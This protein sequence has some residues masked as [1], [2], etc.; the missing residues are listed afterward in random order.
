MSFID[1]VLYAFYIGAVA[2]LVFTPGP[3]VSLI[4]AETLSHS[5]KHGM[6]VIAGA[7]LSTSILLAIYAIGF[8]AVISEISDETLYVIRLL[9]AAYLLYLAL[10]AFRSKPAD[11]S[12]V[13]MKVEH[14]AIKAFKAAL[15]VGAT[16]PKAVLF[17]AA[18]FPQFISPD[19]PAQPQLITLTVTFA[20]LA[21]LLDS[22]WVIAAAS[23]RKFLM[24]SGSIVAINRI[25]GSALALGALLL[26]TLNK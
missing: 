9:G 3:V 16:N 19:L 20:I 25:S 21:P 1:P 5:S 17:F 7:A 14:S 8:G 15:I 6:A 22:C 26:L 24:K 13:E 2:V 11:S 18:F 12:G 10:V 4:I 23:A